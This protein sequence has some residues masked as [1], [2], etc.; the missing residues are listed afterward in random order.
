M[1][2]QPIITL[3][4]HLHK[5]PETSGEEEQTSSFIKE[6]LADLC[7]EASIHK[8]GKYGVLAS[9]EGKASGK[10]IL[11]R[12]ELDALPIEEINDFD[13]RSTYAGKGH[14]CGHDGHMAILLAV[15]SYYHQ[16]KLSYGKVSLL[17]QPAEEIGEGA[18]E[19]LSDPNFAKVC[20]P[21]YVFA[22]HNV[23]GYALH[24]VIYKEQNFT[25]SVI[26]ADV[27]LIG[28]TS[29]AAEP[30]KG[31]NPAYAISDIIKELEK[32]ENVDQ[33][34]DSFGIITHIHISLGSRAYGTSAGMAE[35]G[36]TLRTWSNKQMNILKD[37]FKQ[38]IMQV[39]DKK[40]L[41]FKIEW[42]Q[43]FRA[44][45]NHTICVNMIKNASDDLN[46]TSE[47]KDRPF[48]WGE[49]FGLFTEK[50]PGAMFAIGAG[51]GVPALH[52]PDYDFPDDLI[53][54]GMNMFV[55]IVDLA[56]K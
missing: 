47:V 32:V 33:S 45:Q 36:F 42:S 9:I 27:M 5:F 34:T 6:K 7:P 18:Q 49:D 22:L 10:H 44:I 4:R 1:N 50:Y 21:D 48:K 19:V 28:K 13:H 8:L 54:T 55:Q 51:E 11:L 52:N 56:Q 30:E 2:I 41:K 26:S 37:K 17:F 38:V 14:K 39:C 40:D 15:A 35:M 46:L 23:P 53:E 16:N 25:P 29:H 12:C 43:E 24:K 31:I 20:D 3:R